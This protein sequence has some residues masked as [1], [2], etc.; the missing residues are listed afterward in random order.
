LVPATIGLVAGSVPAR[1]GEAE[2][3]RSAGGG[4]VGG[5]NTGRARATAG[6]ACFGG[7]DPAASIGF[8]GS[9]DAPGFAAGAS[10]IF[11]TCVGAA[12]SGRSLSGISCSSLLL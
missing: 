10:F 5:F 7:E 11:T 3:G 6:G 2:A 9:E 1:S 8:F 12:V 4:T